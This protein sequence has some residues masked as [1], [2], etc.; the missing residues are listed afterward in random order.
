MTALQNSCKKRL[1]CKDLYQLSKFYSGAAINS[2][3]TWLF[4]L[5][6][7]QDPQGN[8]KPERVWPVIEPVPEYLFS[9]M[10][11]SHNDGNLCLCSIGAR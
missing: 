9:P 8:L 3:C 6:I 10:L 4:V 1:S 7:T 2:C 11:G 5:S